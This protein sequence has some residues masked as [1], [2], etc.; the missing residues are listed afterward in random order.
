MALDRRLW[1]LNTEVMSWF[2]SCWGGAGSSL[3]FLFFGDYLTD[4]VFKLAGLG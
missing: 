4:F 1:L 2:C 3:L